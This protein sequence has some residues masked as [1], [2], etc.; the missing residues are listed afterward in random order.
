[1]TFKLKVSSNAL[2]MPVE[3]WSKKSLHLGK[4]QE[5][6]SSLSSQLKIPSVSLYLSKASQTSRF[7]KL[8]EMTE[9]G[10][11]LAIKRV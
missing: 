6:F 10:E 7:Q 3:S 5:R 11:S 9:K 4:I 8:T 2:R 1:M